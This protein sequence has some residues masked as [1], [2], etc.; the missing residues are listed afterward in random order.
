MTVKVCTVLYTMFVSSISLYILVTFSVLKIH[1]YFGSI[2][3]FLYCE[4]FGIF[5]VFFVVVFCVG[6][7]WGVFFL[8]V[9]VAVWGFLFLF[10]FILLRFIFYFKKSSFLIIIFIWLGAFLL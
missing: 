2:L 5:G 8:R 7:F 9:C 10:N 3:L 6:F 4:C 1:M